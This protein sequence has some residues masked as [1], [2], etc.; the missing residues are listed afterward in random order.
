VERWRRIIAILRATSSGSS[1]RRNHPDELHCAPADFGGK[2]VRLCVSG[3]Q[4]CCPCRDIAMADVHRRGT[5]LARQS[6]HRFGLAAPAQ[7]GG[8]GLPPPCHHLHGSGVDV[9]V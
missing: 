7:I 9:K 8:Q 1:R 2:Y 3:G 5:G 4:G 6:R